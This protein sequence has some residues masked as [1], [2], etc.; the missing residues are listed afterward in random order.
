M[1]E[2][3]IIYL[4]DYNMIKICQSNCHH[5]PYTFE[6][7]Y[8]CT[9]LLVRRVVGNRNYPK[10]KKESCYFTGIKTWTELKSLELEILKIIG[11]GIYP[12][13]FIFDDGYEEGEISLWELHNISVQ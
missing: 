12:P 3:Q 8:K 6:Q 2:E 13:D 9:E 10:S 11:F 4:T 1:E 7:I 5:L